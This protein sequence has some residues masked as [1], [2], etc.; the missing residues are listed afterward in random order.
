MTG[1]LGSVHEIVRLLGRA[2]VV[3]LRPI[4]HMY[5][6]KPKLHSRW[7]SPVWVTY[8]QNTCH[9]VVH[10]GKSEKRMP[11]MKMSSAEPSV[12]RKFSRM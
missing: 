6:C 3:F 4:V 12:T 7:N 9:V 5:V 11:V 10:T 1:V 8:I 2:F